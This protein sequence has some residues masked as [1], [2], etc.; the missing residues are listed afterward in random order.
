[1]P[2]RAN[3][4]RRARECPQ[5]HRDN[6]LANRLLRCT[7]DNPALAS[8]IFKS[9]ALTFPP[10]K[11]KKNLRGV[12][13]VDT[14]PVQYLLSQSN[15]LCH[16]HRCFAYWPGIDVRCK[17]VH[18]SVDSLFN[19]HLYVNIYLNQ[20]VGSST[21]KIFDLIL[22]LCVTFVATRPAESEQRILR[23]SV[24]IMP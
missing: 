9:P 20:N 24:I 7:C 10:M 1:M 16:Y 11:H 8:H 15:T 5:K 17:P 2:S 13:R 21:F 3:R 22:K 6:F 12:A 18:F 4:S 23:P 14:S 19:Q